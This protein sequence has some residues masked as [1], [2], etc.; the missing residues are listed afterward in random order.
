MKHHTQ[1]FPALLADLEFT[2]DVPEGFV[3]PPFEPEET[4][5][6]QPERF[7]P[8]AM[9]ASPVA[10]ALISVAARPA[11]DSGSVEQWARYLCDHFGMT[12]TG[13]VSGFVGVPEPDGHLHP[14]VLVEATQTQD[15]TPL[16]MRLIVL[17]DGGRLV[18]AHAMCP[19][20]LWSSFGAALEAAL[21]SIR[22]ARPK[23]PTVPCVPGGP[24]PIVDM[25]G[26]RAGEWPRGRGAEVF[27]VAAHEAALAAA[28]ELA[29]LQIQAGQYVEA[30]ACMARARHDVR[31]AAALARLYKERLEQLVAARPAPGEDS[32]EEVREVFNRAL[33]AALGAYPD[34]H[35]ETEGEDYARG[36]AE[37]EAA[38]VAIMDRYAAGREA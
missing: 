25:P 32:P 7:A 37:D 17:E 34:P 6:S 38:L 5:F 12:I 9:I 8:L 30:E 16:T 28:V 33:A 1:R 3:L 19:D 23:D 27:D 18:T 22:L 21:L 36:Q 4:D 24:V 26:E 14:C 13:L 10:M 20:E 2:M 11:Y 29:R 35:T 31:G 15:G